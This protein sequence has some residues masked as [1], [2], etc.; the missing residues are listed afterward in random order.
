M[1]AGSSLNSSVNV[2]TFSRSQTKK[3]TKTNTK[4]MDTKMTDTKTKTNNLKPKKN[5]HRNGN[6]QAVDS[7]D[8]S[9]SSINMNNIV[10]PNQG[11]KTRSGKVLN[12]ERRTPNDLK[13]HM[14]SQNENSMPNKRHINAGGRQKKLSQSKNTS[15]P[16]TTTRNKKRANSGTEHNLTLKPKI[17]IY[18]SSSFH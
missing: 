16:T 10:N 6:Q 15:I 9:Y 1:S 2:K 4:Q 18:I 5:N 14:N 17:Y 12:N 7:M 13:K 11:M 3:Q 8:E